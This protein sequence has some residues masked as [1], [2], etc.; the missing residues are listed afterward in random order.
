MGL[1]LAVVSAVSKALLV[2]IEPV[3]FFLRVASE[4][5][6]LNRWFVRQLFAVPSPLF[7]V[8]AHFIHLLS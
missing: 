6:F 8:V 2:I 3:D 5:A 1:L 7:V 4:D